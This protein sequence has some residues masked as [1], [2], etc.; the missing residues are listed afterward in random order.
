MN[1]TS[2]KEALLSRV[3]NA[4][5]INNIQTSIKKII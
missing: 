5:D 3:K 1:Y 2:L 4:T